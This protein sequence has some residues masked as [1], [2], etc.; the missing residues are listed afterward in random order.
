MNRGPKIERPR[1]KYCRAL[2]KIKGMA[3]FRMH[4]FAE[5]NFKTLRV[6]DLD[7]ITG[8]ELGDYLIKT[9]QITP[10]RIMYKFYEIIYKTNKRLTVNLFD[11]DPQFNARRGRPI[12]LAFKGDH[13]C[14][15]HLAFWNYCKKKYVNNNI[16]TWLNATKQFM[17][18][19]IIA[20]Q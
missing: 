3:N 2:E 15:L 8:L 7:G 19:E 11:D 13:V 10:T 20:N 9:E 14:G 16:D 18:T 6:C 5:P 12:K 1:K 4:D 17:N